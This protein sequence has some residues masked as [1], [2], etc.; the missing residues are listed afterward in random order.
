MK[1]TEDAIQRACIEY[2]KLEE[3][4]GK[5]TFFHVPNGGK[6]NVIEA[7]RFK[8]LGVRAGVYD[9]AIVLPEARAVFVEVKAPKSYASKKQKE[10]NERVSNLSCPTAI[11]RSVTD[12]QEFLRPLL[13]RSAA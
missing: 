7:A 2:L 8:K 4:L 11:V 12:L 9:L 5:L 6:R 1:R 10:F 3:N 13:D